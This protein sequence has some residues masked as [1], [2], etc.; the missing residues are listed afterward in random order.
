LCHLTVFTTGAPASETARV[1]KD[2]REAQPAPTVTRRGVEAHD[3]WGGLRRIRGSLTVLH[4]TIRQATL[5]SRSLRTGG[6]FVFDAQGA[7]IKQREF[8]PRFALAVPK[9][10]QCPMPAAGYP[11]VM[12]AHGTGGD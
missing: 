9:Q 3:P 12:Y 1:A 5:R 7:P 8:S 6:G 10:A 4:R 11:I 2:A